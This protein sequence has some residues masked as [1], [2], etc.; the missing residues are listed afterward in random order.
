MTIRYAKPVGTLMR[1]ITGMKPVH[2]RFATLSRLQQSLA[3]TLPPG[4]KRHAVWRIWR[5]DAGDRRGQWCDGGEVETDAS[6][7]V[8]KHSGRS[9]W[10][11]FAAKIK[12]K[13]NR[14]HQFQSWC[15]PTSPFSKRPFKGTSGGLECWPKN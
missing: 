6:A 4:L 12:L 1:E 7:L 3:D 15:N 5:I 8:L 14:L 10:K 11:A 13:N 9:L 2:D